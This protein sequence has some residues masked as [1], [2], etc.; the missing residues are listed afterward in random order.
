[1]LY[2]I[3]GYQSSPAGEKAILFA[4]QLDARPI[5]YRDCPP[6]E[7]IIDDCIDRIIATTKDDSSVQFIGSSL[8]GFLAAKTALTADS[9][10]TLILL[11]PAIIPPGTDIASI[12]SVPQSILADMIEPRLFSTKLGAKVYIIRGTEDT[13]VPTEWVLSFAHAQEATIQLVNDDH[14]LSKTLPQLPQMIASLLP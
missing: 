7:L 4:Q 14:R 9:V 10:T 1:M 3:H 2:Y 11:N 6:E 12:H 8:G 5:R 13:V